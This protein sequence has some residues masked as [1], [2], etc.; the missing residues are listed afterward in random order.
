MSAA[1]EQVQWLVATGVIND[2]AREI[3]PEIGKAVAE[4]LKADVTEAML[5]LIESDPHL[6][7]K[8]PCQTCRAVSAL[9]GR[10]FGCVAKGEG[11]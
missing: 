1:I 2:L 9:A 5:R 4:S 3:A 8:R 11:V 7:S 10:S 6:W